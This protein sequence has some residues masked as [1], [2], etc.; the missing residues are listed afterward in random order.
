MK[1]AEKADLELLFGHPKAG[2][3]KVDIKDGDNRLANHHPDMYMWLSRR[4][5]GMD[6]MMCHVLGPTQPSRHPDT[7]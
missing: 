6:E 3:D 2:G 7:C 5:L 1:D 4:D